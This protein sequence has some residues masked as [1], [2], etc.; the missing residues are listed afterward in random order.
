MSFI[1]V[2]RLSRLDYERVIDGMP[3]E[4]RVSALKTVVDKLWALVCNENK[5]RSSVDFAT[6]MQV[7]NASSAAPQR[8]SDSLARVLA[9]PPAD[10]EGAGGG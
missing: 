6:Y 5:G 10:R 4:A 7:V 3:E 1:Q 8:D 2:F 9:A